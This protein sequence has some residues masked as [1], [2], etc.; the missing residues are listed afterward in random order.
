LPKFI[1]KYLQLLLAA[2]GLTL[3]AIVAYVAASCAWPW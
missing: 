1:F 3:L 2:V